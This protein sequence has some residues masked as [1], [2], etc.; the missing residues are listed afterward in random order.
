MGSLGN[1]QACIPLVLLDI[2]MVPATIQPSATR[3]SSGLLSLDA[4]LALACS[5]LRAMAHNCNVLTQPRAFG[6]K[7][8]FGLLR[9]TS[10]TRT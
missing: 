10:R 5:L 6:G 8:D 2:M 4:K 9:A 7:L 3:H 1:T